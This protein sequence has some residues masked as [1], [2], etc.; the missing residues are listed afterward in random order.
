[1]TN[2]ASIH[3][4]PRV[5]EGRG[6]GRCRV[7]HWRRVHPLPP[8]GAPAAPAVNTGERQTVRYLFRWFE[9]GNRWHNVEQLH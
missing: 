1:M 3:Q 9:E 6:H 2:Q 5:L 4:S 8:G 7:Q